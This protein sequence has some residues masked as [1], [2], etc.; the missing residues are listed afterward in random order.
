M[1]HGVVIHINS[2]SVGYK[3]KKGW[4]IV[5][6]GSQRNTA[7]TNFSDTWVSK[8]TPKSPYGEEA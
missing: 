7:D 8:T 1:V 6:G 2:E 4:K 5:A 3:P